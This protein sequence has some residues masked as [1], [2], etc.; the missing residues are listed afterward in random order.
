MI[1]SSRTGLAV[2]WLAALAVIAGPLCLATQSAFAAKPPP[3]PPPAAPTG[4]IYYRDG[5]TY[6]A[7]KPDG[8]GQAADILPNIAALTAPAYGDATPAFLPSGSNATHDRWWVYPATTG[9]YDRWINPDGTVS[10]N[11]PHRDLFAVR[12]DPE[13]RSQLITVQLTD[14]Y[15]VATIA[16]AMAHL[17]NDTNNDPLTS[18]AIPLVSDLRGRFSEEEDGTTVVDL[19]QLG[20]QSHSMR[21]P[22]TISEIEP[23]YVPFGP[24]TADEAELDAMLLPV[25]YGAGYLIPNA[26][27]NQGAIAPSGD[28]YLRIGSSKLLIQDWLSGSQTVLW[29]G[30][31]GAPA[32]P[33]AAQWSPDGAKVA[34]MNN[35]SSG[36]EIWTQPASGSASPSKLLAATVK[37]NKRTDYTDPNWS[38]DSKYLVVVKNE[39]IGGTQTGC[40]LT[41]VT[42]ADRKTLD[43]VP[44]PI[45][46]SPGVSHPIL[47]WT[48]DN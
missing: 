38:P 1:Q 19:S 20:Q 10:D 42:V 16:P 32:N 22:L 39:Y 18:F 40:W 15:G 14:L 45:S 37:G 6:Y 13:D 27:G 34:I 28:V 41:R 8:S 30:S 33:W 4:T 26:V 46:G 31:T 21:F 44:L 17:S 48:A 7:V 9:V 43:L 11:R 47:R 24:D 5:T 2:R 35:G 36:F 25:M 29:D 3:P 12:S 23:G